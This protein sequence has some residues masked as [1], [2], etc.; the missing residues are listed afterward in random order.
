MSR[1][2]TWKDAL[3]IAMFAGVSSALIF[4]MIDVAAAQILKD[5]LLEYYNQNDNMVVLIILGGFMLSMVVAIIASVLAS[6]RITRKYAYYA[7]LLAFISNFALWILISVI[8]TYQLSPEYRALGTLQQIVNIPMAMV[9]LAIFYLS[10]ITI[11]WLLTQVTFAILFAFYLKKLGSRESK[12][13][14][15]NYKL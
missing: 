15:S 5:T 3:S 11:F 13:N 12:S 4:L 7:S 6:Q 8:A 10:N 1:K 14:Y 2:I 9:Y